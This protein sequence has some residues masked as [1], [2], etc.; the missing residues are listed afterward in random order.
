[1][2]GESSLMVRTRPGWLADPTRRRGHDELQHRVADLQAVAA[3]HRGRA[4]D[5]LAV[6]ERAVGRAEVLDEQLPVT[7]EHAGVELRRVGVVD[8]DAAAGGPPDGELVGDREDAAPL[9]GRLDHGELAGLGLAGP[10]ALRLGRGR[11]RGRAGGRADRDAT[12]GHRGGL[13][14][15]LRAVDLDPD[16]PE[17][18]QEEQV[19]QGQKAQLQ[20]GEQLLHL[21][22]EPTGA[23]MATWDA[24]GEVPR[25][26][27]TSSCG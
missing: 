14:R 18:S 1:M 25:P 3:A 26:G 16:R 27:A 19:E 9:V 5:L 10:P 20:D 2:S 23:P 8:R 6:E 13:R 7:A 12:G 21:G 17:H 22:P 11:R 15:L 24:S 4:G